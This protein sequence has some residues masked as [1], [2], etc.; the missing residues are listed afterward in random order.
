MMDVWSALQS[1]LA[2]RQPLA[3]CRLVATRGSTPQKPGAAMLVRPD[4]SQVGTLG[5]GCVEAEVKR[6]ALQVLQGGPPEVL[7]FHLDH[8]YGWDDGLICGGRMQILVL[9]ITTPQ[10]AQY[11]QALAR[12]AM[13]GRGFT[14]VVSFA[15]GME[16][17]AAQLLL[18][19][20]DGALAAALGTP[21]PGE[22]LFARARAALR[23]LADRPRPYLAGQMAFLPVLPRL[24]LVIIGG[25][26]VGLAVARLAHELEFSVWVVDDRPEFVSPER[27]PQAERRIS[28][29]L[30]QVLSDLPVDEHTYVLIVT[31]GH[32][33][34]QLALYY[35]ARRP[36][37]YL[38]MI[39]SRRKIRLIFEHLLDE[40]IPAEALQ[41]VYAPVG[42][43]IGSQTVEEIA[44]SICAELVAH[45]NRGVVPGRDQPN[46]VLP[47]RTGVP[48]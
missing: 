21:M 42:I 2:S 45:R 13:D 35:M 38:G 37:G 43:D 12:L 39:G 10:A 44:V 25:G 30:D 1:L 32:Q 20:A 15:P 48:S 9:P 16:R 14:E 7:T 8:D 6:Q 23:P 11:G 27:F 5:G 41:R 17:A 33:H 31:R 19:D 40:G 4:G 24:R 34:D 22:E 47:A 28:G 36:A 26:H 29:P 3:Y 18:V 46:S